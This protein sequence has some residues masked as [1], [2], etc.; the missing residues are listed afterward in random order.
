MQTWNNIFS[1]S[2]SLGTW[3][4]YL[5]LLL[6]P[7][8]FPKIAQIQHA[9][10][11][12]GC[13]RGGL[14]AT[15]LTAQR[16]DG[17][18]LWIPWTFAKPRFQPPSA[19]RIRRSSFSSKWSFFHVYR[20]IDHEDHEYL[21][22][23]PSTFSVSWWGAQTPP[24]VVSHKNWFWRVLVVGIQWN[25][26]VHDTWHVPNSLADQTILLASW[27]FM[28]VSKQNTAIVKTCYLFHLCRVLGL[29]IED[30][31]KMYIQ[32]YI[33]DEVTSCLVGTSIITTHMVESIFMIV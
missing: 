20:S 23:K 26:S 28:C 31:S 30:I 12:A 19:I 5:Y 1:N 24:V 29:A 27:W 16:T 21:K 15:N 10:I 22:P 32:C 25:T 7:P 18:F 11:L 4:T 17:T 13:S 8:R 3:G 33:N 14:L 2:R 9:E 6:A